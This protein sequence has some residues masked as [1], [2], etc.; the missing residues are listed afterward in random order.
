MGPAL[1]YYSYY[2]ETS[3]DGNVFFTLDS[4]SSDLMDELICSFSSSGGISQNVHFIDGCPNKKFIIS[5][6]NSA[7]SYD[8]WLK[9]PLSQ[10]YLQMRYSYNLENNITNMLIGILPEPKL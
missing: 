10:R 1:M 7:E 3:L 9:N 2:L 8:I 4:L 6:W 5:K